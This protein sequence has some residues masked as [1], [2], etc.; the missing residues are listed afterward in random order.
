MNQV[1]NMLHQVLIIF[2][3]QVVQNKFPLKFQEMF[4]NNEEWGGLISDLLSKLRLIM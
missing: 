4:L 1:E 2:H 3:G